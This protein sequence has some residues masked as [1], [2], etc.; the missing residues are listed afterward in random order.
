MDD[1]DS[2][3]DEVRASSVAEHLHKGGFQALAASSKETLIGQLGVAFTKL[4][5]DEG[6]ARAES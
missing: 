3:L 2:D 6:V 1:F 5:M 4:R